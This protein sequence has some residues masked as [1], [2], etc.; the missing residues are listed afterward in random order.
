[1]KKNNEL[2]HL[3]QLTDLFKYNCDNLKVFTDPIEDQEANDKLNNTKNN[4]TL[5]HCVLLYPTPD[6]DSQIGLIDTL[7]CEFPQN[8]IGY[9][10][11]TVPCQ[12]LKILKTV[13]SRDISLL[14][15]HYTF[16]K[17]LKGNDHYHAMDIY[18]LKKI[19]LDL[20]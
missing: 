17:N 1:M 9:S 4:V 19:D 11:H 12:E 8:P 6:D 18:D 13:L 15:K 16:N 20:F 14:E 7:K 10:D 3:D 2:H 5:L